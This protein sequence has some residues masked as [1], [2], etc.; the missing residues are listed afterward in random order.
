MWG[1]RWSVDAALA[2]VNH[3]HKLA[4][5]I[6]ATGCISTSIRAMTILG[7]VEAIPAG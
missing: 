2:S 5:G 4:L 1:G 6:A 3:A 7:A